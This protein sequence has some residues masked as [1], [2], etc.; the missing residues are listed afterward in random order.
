MNNGKDLT[1]RDVQAL[2]LDSRE[3]VIAA[4]MGKFLNASPVQMK[5]RHL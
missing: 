2:F 1:F 3:T 5:T 4:R